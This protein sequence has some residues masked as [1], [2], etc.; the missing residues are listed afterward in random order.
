MA[1]IKIPKGPITISRGIHDDQSPMICVQVSS[2]PRLHLHPKHNLPIRMQESDMKFMDSDLSPQAKAAL[3][4]VLAEVEAKLLAKATEA[5]KAM[6][7]E[8]G[9]KL[10]G[11]A[12]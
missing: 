10:D 11:H 3:D 8:I 5:A 9:V 1:T 2:T 7:A 12:T 4:L 6:A